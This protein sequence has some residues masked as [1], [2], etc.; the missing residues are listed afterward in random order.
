MR[1][2]REKVVVLE[3]GLKTQELRVEQLESMLNARETEVQQL[4]EQLAES[5]EL[6]RKY[7]SSP[8]TPPRR[9]SLKVPPLVLI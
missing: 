3:K 5:S 9:E 2:E 1:E 8:D 7:Q 4:Q 6:Q